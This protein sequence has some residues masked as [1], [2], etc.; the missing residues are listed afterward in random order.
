MFDLVGLDFP[1]AKVRVIS[2]FLY[3][4]VEGGSGRFGSVVVHAGGPPFNFALGGSGGLKLQTHFF[5]KNVISMFLQTY[6]FGENGDGY[7]CVFDCVWIREQ[8]SLR[9]CFVVVIVCFIGG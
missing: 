9:K 6:P 7:C 3:K 1:R 5:G 2:S 4:L 8:S